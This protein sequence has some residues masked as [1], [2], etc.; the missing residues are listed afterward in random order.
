MG[1]PVAIEKSWM[2]GACRNTTCMEAVEK[3]LDARKN[4]QN[5]EE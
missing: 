3:C 5:P 2:L 4:A 1:L